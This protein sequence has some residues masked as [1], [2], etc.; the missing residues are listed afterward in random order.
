MTPRPFFARATAR[1]L[2]SDLPFCREHGLLPEVYLPGEALDGGMASALPLL[3]AWREEGRALT[4]HAPFKH[5]S[6]GAGDPLVGAAAA[7]RFGQLLDAAEKARPAH[8]V[9]HHGYDG[10]RYEWNEKAW[11]EQSAR[12]WTPVI[13]R[14]AALGVRVV[15]ENVFDGDPGAM[16]LLRERLGKG[17]AGFCFDSGHFLLFAR[18]PLEDWLGAFGDGLWEMHLH[19]NR[20]D[21]DS[22]LPVGSGIFD[23]PSLFRH[24]ARCGISPLIV[25]ENHRHEEVLPSREACLALMKEARP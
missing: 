24:L 7:R 23:F 19:D 8:I 18:T 1:T 22:H 4:F 3:L 25:L 14:A 11:L 10:W 2:D 20:A 12:F 9:F 5:L 17:A 21:R 15:F 16:L 6:P 13:E